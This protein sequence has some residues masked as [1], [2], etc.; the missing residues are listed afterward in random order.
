VVLTRHPD[1]IHGKSFFQKDAPTSTP[2]WVRTQ[3]IRAETPPK[4]IEYI[5]IDDV[6]TLRYVVNLGT[7][8]IHLWA[9]RVA[10]LERPDWMVLDLDPKG[11]PFTDVVA[12]ALA[13]RRVLERL[14]VPGY[15]KTSGKTGLHVLVPLGARHGYEEVRGLA[16]I[17]ATL[18]VDEEPRRAT[19]ARPLHARGGKVY[20]DWGQNGRGQTIVAPF[21]VR[22][23]PGA[24]VSCPLTWDEV[25]PSLDPMAFTMRTAPARFARL[26]DPMAPV[27]GPGIDLPAI[28]RRI[29]GEFG[30]EER[31][32]DSAR[33]VKPPSRRGR[34]SAGRTRGRSRSPRA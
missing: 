27:L 19:V 34:G 13:V 1:G 25:V 22:P 20:V 11:A 14:E 30:A 23:L 17:I 12:I 18:V 33:G 10:A 29:E 3:S 16:E 9:S 28:L 31:A 26:R 5:V 6:Q 21:S 4:N 2:A 7:I 8:P 15:V 32:A 24:P